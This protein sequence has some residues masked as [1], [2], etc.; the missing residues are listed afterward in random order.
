MLE[1]RNI[2]EAEDSDFGSR[3][4][5][6]WKCVLPLNG[7]PG[8]SHLGTGDHGPKTNRSRPRSVPVNDLL[9]STW[10]IYGGK[11]KEDHTAAYFESAAVRAFLPSRSICPVV[12]CAYSRYSPSAFSFRKT[13]KK[14]PLSAP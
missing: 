9:S 14:P 1:W 5:G 12:T 8:A 6:P 13:R 2:L 10:P 7:C 4:W 3:A 11:V